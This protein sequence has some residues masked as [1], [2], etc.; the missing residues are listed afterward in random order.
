MSMAGPDFRFELLDDS[1][2]DNDQPCR[3]AAQQERCNANR[4]ANRQQDHGGTEPTRTSRCSNQFTA[5]ESASRKIR[6]VKSGM[7]TALAQL[8][9]KMLANAARSTSDMLRMLTGTRISKGV[10]SLALCSWSACGADHAGLLPPSSR[11]MSA[12]NMLVMV[13]SDARCRASRCLLRAACSPP[14]PD[15]CREMAG[16]RGRFCGRGALPSCS[17]WFQGHGVGARPDRVACSSLLALLS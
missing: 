13:T 7:K 11:R 3:L 2:Q 5:G 15:S 8:N 9:T 14:P 17:G 6:L 1:R 12:S 4:A 16:W 10:G